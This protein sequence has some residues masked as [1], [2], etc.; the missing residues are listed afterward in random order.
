MSCRIDRLVTGKDLVVLCISGRITGQHVDVV[1]ALLEQERSPFAI[2]LKDVLLV[3]RDAVKLL[4][5]TEINGTELRNSPAY[6]REWVAWERSDMP[7]DRS[8]EGTRGRENI[9]D[10]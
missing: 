10:V 6:I 3:D 7:A 2:D 5:L 1:R 9:E 8:E 4:A